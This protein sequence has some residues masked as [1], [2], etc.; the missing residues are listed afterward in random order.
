M[1][2]TQE[3]IKECQMIGESWGKSEIW[4]WKAEHAE[5]IEMPAWTMGTYCGD[6][7][8]FDSTEEAEK[9]IDAAARTAWEALR[10]ESSTLS[11]Y[12]AEAAM[13]AG[14]AILKSVY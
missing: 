11:M 9:I 5:G 6:L 8:D 2:L 10:H 4:L 12:Q 7:N 13:E 14:K 1:S 3:Q